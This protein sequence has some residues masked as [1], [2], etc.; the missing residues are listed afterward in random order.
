[1]ATLLDGLGVAEG[2]YRDIQPTPRRAGIVQALVMVP[3]MSLVGLRWTTM[4]AALST[5]LS[6]AGVAW[7]PSVSWWWLGLAWLVLFSPAGRTA[8]PETGARLLLRD[9]LPGS[10]PRGGSVHFRQ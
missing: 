1:L 3:L 8:V 6:A 10:Y 9:V 4:L 7:A 5:V 2:K